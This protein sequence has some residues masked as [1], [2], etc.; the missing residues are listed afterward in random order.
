MVITGSEK[1]AVRGVGAVEDAV[2]LAEVAAEAMGWLP[3]GE[4]M[5]LHRGGT[6]APEVPIVVTGMPDVALADMNVLLMG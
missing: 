2:F 5:Y 4:G 1:T 6:E 3:L